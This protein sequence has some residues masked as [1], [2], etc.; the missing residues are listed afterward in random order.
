M[1]GKDINQNASK[2]VYLDPQVTIS[3][4]SSKKTIV[5]PQQPL[6]FIA[7]IV[8]SVCIALALYIATLMID[9]QWDKIHA[10]YA[11]LA[12]LLMQFFSEFLHLYQNW[13]IR[14][15][16]LMIAKSLVSWVLTTGT[17][18]IFA[19]SFDQS[20]YDLDWNLGI[21]WFLLT[22]A[23]FSFARMALNLSVRLMRKNGVNVKRIAIAGAGPIARYVVEQIQDNPWTG[24]EVVGIYDDRSHKGYE[25]ERIIN[26]RKREEVGNIRHGIQAKGTFAQMIEDA[27]HNEFDLIFIALPMRAEHKIQEIIRLLS[28]S[29]VGVYVVP[30]FYS[31]ETHY[32][33]LVN[34]NGMPAVSIYENPTSG[35]GGVVK[36]LEDILFA[37][38][39]LS[40][41]IIPM[42]FIAIGVKLTSKGPIIFKQ[43]RY[44]LD[45][46]PIK[47]WKFRS[48]RVMENKEK[49]VQ[50]KRG[51]PRITPFGGFLRKTSL[52]ELPQ[53]FNVIQGT[54]S[55]VGPRP[56]AVAH[57]E[58]YRK[59]IRGY[60]LRHKT[61]P[62]ITGWAQINGF[63]GETDSLDKM[64]NRVVYD[65]D[66]IR[67]WSVFFDIKIIL[68]T[69]W[70]G[71]TGENAY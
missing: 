30:D 67:R 47:V 10:F 19:I 57:N 55:V 28:A 32:T 27:V 69:V 63:R 14:H 11:V 46:K 58:E 40:I 42:I 43:I 60:M 5:T 37:S 70:K 22:F 15:T 52:D 35:L 31:I 1:L 4:L 48:M 21:H 16:F 61:K 39:I 26:K 33:H 9:S 38:I 53:F 20:V 41:I 17:L 50:A 68:M 36:R 51:D 24:Y 44:G 65:I 45:G 59:L 29:T 62:G 23:C 12:I 34:I 56:H 54:M 64:Q 25:L 66:Y 3:Q 49:V 2:V 18:F 8:D 13:R 6:A 7:R 71:F